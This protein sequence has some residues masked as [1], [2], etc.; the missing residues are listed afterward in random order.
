MH[1]SNAL[2][3]KRK[4]WSDLT[5][6]QISAA[7][8]L[9][10]DERMW[11]RLGGAKNPIEDK[12]WDDLT[13]EE[14]CA[15]ITLGYNKYIWSEIFSSGTFTGNNGGDGRSIEDTNDHAENATTDEKKTE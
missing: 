8:I 6:D 9:G 10:Y 14:L 11:N 15:G 12:Q 5:K 2:A 13:S 1:P 3:W 4:K 7:R